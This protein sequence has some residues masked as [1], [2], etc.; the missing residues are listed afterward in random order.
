MSTE[1]V[2]TDDYNKDAA[3]VDDTSI[4]LDGGDLSDDELPSELE[5][6]GKRVSEL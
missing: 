1:P 2:P 5:M 4:S 6:M 3:S